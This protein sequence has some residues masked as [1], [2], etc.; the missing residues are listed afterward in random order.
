MT[1]LQLPFDLSSVSAARRWVGSQLEDWSEDGRRAAMLVTSELASN[2]ILHARTNIVVAFDRDGERCRIA[3]ADR[4]RRPPVVKQYGEDAS[5]GRGLRLVGRLSSE[6]GV[7]PQPNGK[8]VWAVVHDRPWGDG[9]EPTGPAV[10]AR[11]RDMGEIPP[12]DVPDDSSV[13]ASAPVRIRLIGVPL[14]VMFEAEQHHDGLLREF[15]FLAG[16]RH[17]SARLEALAQEVEAHFGAEAE[18]VKTEVDAAAAGGRD[19]VDL[20]V[21][22]SRAAWEALDRLLQLLDEADG[23]CQRVELLT[24]ASSPAVRRLRNW[25]GQ[26][27]RRQMDGGPP[28]PWDDAS[29]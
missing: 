17:L 25:Y 16:S 15:S 22:Q 29:P 14:A 2:V 13:A 11:V 23:H 10:E 26:E 3:V 21:E 5:T 19:T 27:L 18:R 8:E 28:T 9:R 12:D 7:D 20:S 24:L 6:W 1:E 4:D